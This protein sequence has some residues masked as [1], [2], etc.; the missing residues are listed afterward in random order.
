MIV[1]DVKNRK[2]VT[3]SDLIVIYIVGRSHL[4]A[5]CTEIHCHI[6]VLD[7]RN[8]LVDQWDKDLL[9]LEPVITLICRIH[10]HSGIRHDCLWAGCS[11]NDILICRIS[12][13]VRDE[14]SHMV[15][16]ADSVLV[17]HFLVTYGCESHRVPV[18]H[19]HA[20]I[21]VSFI[22]EVYE[23]ADHSI[24][25]LRIHSELGPVPVA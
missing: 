7:D 6:A 24:A 12:V 21:D 23:C 3:H 16:L 11:D 25:E 15:E 19:A 9:T 18:H 4:E 13:S 1:D 14:I 17:D 8:L 10:A 5:S 22:I 20:S 2:V